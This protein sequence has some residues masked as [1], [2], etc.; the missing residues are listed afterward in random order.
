[1]RRTPPRRGL[2]ARLLWAG[3]TAFSGLMR[4]AFQLLYYPFSFT[5][6]AVAWI[7]SAGEW[8]DWRRCVLPYL[9]PGRVLDL[10]H[11]TGTLALDMAERGFPSRQW[12][13]HRRW[14]K[15]R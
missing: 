15:S 5:Y 11:G 14:E 7:V 3:A 1:M 4:F 10:A 6:D 8:A 12:I 13:F 9:R 2:R